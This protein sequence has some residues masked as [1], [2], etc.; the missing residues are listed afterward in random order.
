MQNGT[1]TACSGTFLDSG[2]STANYG[3][4]ESFVYTICPENAG[5]FVRLDFSSF[6]TQTGDELTIYDGD[7]TTADSLGTFSNTNS[8]GII[9][10]SS[11]SGCLTFEFISSPAVGGIGWEAAISCY[12][13][14]QTITAVLDSTNPVPNIDGEIIICVGGDV[15]FVGSA[16]FS[17]DPTGATYTWDFGNETTATGTNVTA[18]YDSPGIYVVDLLVTDD[19]PEGC[20]NLNSI[21]QIVRVS[22]EIDFTG[23]QAA[24]SSI[25]YGETITIEGVAAIA[26][27]EDC[28]PEIF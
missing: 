4:D 17:S 26:P 2:G 13:P 3:N 24:Q 8:P 10:A 20:N 18:F 28:A 27:F 15:E 19:N 9:I 6:V 1:E 25:C 14:C 12:E 21:S 23:T 7:S 22:P 11:T 16:T 5:Q